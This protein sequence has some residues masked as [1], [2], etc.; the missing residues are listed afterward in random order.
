MAIS[1]D[2]VKAIHV[3]YRELLVKYPHWRKG[4]AAFQAVWQTDRS[5]A[6]LI[7]ASQV[8]PYF[9]DARL[10]EFWTFLSSLE[11]T[12]TTAEPTD[13]DSNAWF[14]HRF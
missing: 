3:K 9:E 2:K 7:S 13:A 11:A 12:D 8:D 14:L 1:E 6:E 5:L 4:Q 10:D